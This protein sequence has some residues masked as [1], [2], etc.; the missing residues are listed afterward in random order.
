M[1]THA[2]IVVLVGGAAVL[3][4]RQLV[5]RMRDEAGIRRIR[6]AALG[7][8]L[9]ARVRFRHPTDRAR[10]VEGCVLT[11]R[12]SPLCVAWVRVTIEAADCS[13]T[14]YEVTGRGWAVVAE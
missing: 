12:E 9:G 4:L 8:H 1:L 2:V 5:A 14:D 10:M 6:L 11:V 7:G 3:V 13:R